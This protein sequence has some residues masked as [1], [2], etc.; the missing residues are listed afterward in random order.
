MRGPGARAAHDAP[1]MADLPPLSAAPFE[2]RVVVGDAHLDDN[3]HVNNVVYLQWMND[4]AVAHWTSIASPDAQARVAWVARRHEIDY[5]APALLGEELVVRTWI[6]E[7]D[8]LRFL[9]FCEVRRAS[10]G[11][12]LVS[13]RTVWI[14]VDATTGRPRRVPDD[15]RRQFSA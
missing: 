7:A 1:L 3:R 2:Q 9:R 11:K 10:D 13:L 14:P 6:G 8:G 15:V 5:H 4:V 12:V